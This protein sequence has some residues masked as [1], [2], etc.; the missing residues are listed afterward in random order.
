MKD[1]IRTCG[2]MREEDQIKEV[3][4][5]L[6]RVR[7]RVEEAC[8][9]VDRDPSSVTLVAVIKTFG[10]GVIRAAHAAG[11]T[12]FGE[13]YAQDLRDKSAALSDLKD[14]N[15]HFVGRIQTNKVK[16]L[17]GT[18]CL[19]HSVDRLETAEAISKRI[20]KTSGTPQDVLVAVN[21]GSENTKSGVLEQDAPELCE[22]IGA[23]VGVRLK[24]LMCLP[25]WNPDPQLSRPYFRGLRALADSIRGNIPKT[26]LFELSMGMSHDL[27]VAI[28]EGATLI[29][30]GTALFGPRTNREARIQSERSSLASH[31][32]GNND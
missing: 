17:A 25:P 22:R 27:E 28:E 31:A 23:L 5:R 24:G 3:S 12:E 21:I 19:V 29:R 9:R 16:Y 7:L 13:S 18:S 6:A 1:S 32:K 14:I 10:T 2:S 26:S 15:W 30:V 20:M 11:L 4:E 8:A